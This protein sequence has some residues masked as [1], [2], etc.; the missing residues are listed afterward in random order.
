MKKLFMM[1]VIIAILVTLAPII[2]VSGAPN[3]AKPIYEDALIDLES[4]PG[5]AYGEVKMWGDGIIKIELFDDTAIPGQKY[6]VRMDCGA[7]PLRP[8]M[9]IATGLMTSSEDGYAIEYFNIF[10]DTP[11]EPGTELFM[12]GFM[13]IRQEPL[14]AV[15]VNG[16][17]IPDL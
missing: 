13:I 1:A 12:P 3:G 4:T 6:S 17:A 7:P 14:G 10:E 5:T 16:L 8:P 9:S 11:L 2:P 15:A